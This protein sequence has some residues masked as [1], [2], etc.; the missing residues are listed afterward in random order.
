M[1]RK[2]LKFFW[3]W[4]YEKE[5]AWLNQMSAQGWQLI[6][7]GFCLYTFKE[8]VPGEYL[9]KLEFMD[10]W[11]SR[12]NNTAYI[13][14][15]EETGI[16]HVDSLFRWAYFRK[17]ANEGTFE[18][19]SDNTSKIKHYWRIISMIGLLGFANA[20]QIPGSLHRLFD[21]R[22]GTSWIVIFV[23]Q[24]VLTLLFIVGITRLYVKIRRLKKEQTFKE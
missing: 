8:G 4:Q 18:L 1:I 5:E 22:Y 13:R 12:V 11:F 7:V 24:V 23:F 21:E 14:F 15:L 17:K 16:E 2:V 6:S 19:Y 3:V 10:T 20:C 9:Y